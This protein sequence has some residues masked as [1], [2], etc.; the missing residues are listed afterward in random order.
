MQES[1]VQITQQLN[2]LL[3]E[4]Q[5]DMYKQVQGMIF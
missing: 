1:Q 4:N 3:R 2:A 5:Q